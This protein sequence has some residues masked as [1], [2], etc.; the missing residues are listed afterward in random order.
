[1]YVGDAYRYT[2]QPIYRNVQRSFR[3]HVRPRPAPPVLYQLWFYVTVPGTGFETD[4]LYSAVSPPSDA[5]GPSRPPPRG[6]GEAAAARHHVEFVTVDHKPA[7]GAGGGGDLVL[8]AW[9]PDVDDDDDDDAGEW[10]YATS[11]VTTAD[12]VRRRSSSSS[13]SFR[14]QQVD[15]NVVVTETS[16]AEPFAYST[17]TWVAGDSDRTTD[18]CV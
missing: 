15:D 2:L 7:N 16:F 8:R 12:D 14:L 3:C 4:R 9:R 13:S 18:R 10:R 11:A 1:M 6:P 17:S 5:A